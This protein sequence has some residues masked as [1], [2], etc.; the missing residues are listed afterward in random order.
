ME[1]LTIFALLG[2]SGAEFITLVTELLGQIL[3]IGKGVSKGCSKKKK[4]SQVA[5]S[6]KN[7]PKAKER[8]ENGEKEQNEV[9]VK[10]SKLQKQKLDKSGPENEEESLSK[11]KSGDGVTEPASGLLGKKKS[12]HTFLRGHPRK[13]SRQTPLQ[14]LE[15]RKLITDYWDFASS[16]G[17]EMRDKV[18]D[19]EA[20]ESLNPPHHH[21][22]TIFDKEEEAGKGFEVERKINI[23]VQSKR[24]V[25]DKKKILAFGGLR[26]K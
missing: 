25:K 2:A 6:E 24:R 11:Q 20:A 21:Q 1:Q 23:S 10:Q 17:G 19:T 5:D 4:K 3:S 12:V 7:A 8:Q 14:P 22:L 18:L 9:K 15:H 13:P 26:K 16:S